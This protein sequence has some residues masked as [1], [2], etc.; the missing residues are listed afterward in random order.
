MFFNFP[1]STNALLFWFVGLSQKNLFTI[2]EKFIVAKKLKIL[3]FNSSFKMFCALQF[4]RFSLQWK[5][6]IEIFLWMECQKMGKDLFY[7]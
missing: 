6:T 2:V 4:I 7:L 3:F 5:Q 1:S